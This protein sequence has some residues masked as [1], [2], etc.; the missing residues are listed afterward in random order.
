MKKQIF[1]KE[2][3]SSVWKSRIILYLQQ[4]GYVTYANRLADIKFIIADVYHGSRISV[5]AMFPDKAEIVINPAMVDEKQFLGQKKKMMDQLSVLVR[6]EL[7]HF[8]LVH[9]KRMIIHL[10]K[11]D[12]DWEKKYRGYSIRRLAN[13]AMD[14][15]LSQEGYDEHDKEVVRLMT[16]NGSVIGGLI[17][18]D[19]HPEWINLTFEELL[20]KVIEEKEKAIEQ[21]KKDLEQRE[22]EQEQQNQEQNTQ[23]SNS[24]SSDDSD[25]D[26]S[27]ED[28]DDTQNNDQTSDQSEN[29]D[30]DGDEDTI[31]DEDESD[32]ED[33]VEDEEDSESESSNDVDPEGNSDDMEKSKMYATA[34][35][36]VIDRF[37]KDEISAEELEQLIADIEAGKIIEL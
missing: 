10:S 17:L 33:N 30:E 13:K 21:A 16:K 23:D 5:A 1:L 26:N 12:S 34:W 11:K 15:N 8:L 20:D 37:D 6:H 14:W 4:E 29:E 32:D 25:S 9:S 2:S 7:L 31:E 22:K 24:S 35:N 3:L 36:E 18:S 27:S 19:D 28:N